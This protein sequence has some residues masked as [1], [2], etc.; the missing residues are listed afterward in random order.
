MFFLM[1]LNFVR[2]K[3]HS[4]FLGQFNQ[5]IIPGLSFEAARGQT[6]ALVGQ[7]G[8]GKSTTIQLT[9]RFYDAMS[10]NVVSKE[11]T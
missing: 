11:V 6:I 5:E 3:H 1:T 8:C 4:Q 9:E 10:G 7:S 2:L